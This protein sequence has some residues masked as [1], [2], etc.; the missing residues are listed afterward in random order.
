MTKTALT[1]LQDETKPKAGDRLK[2]GEILKTNGTLTSPNG[3]FIFRNQED[4]NFVLY[5]KNFENR[6]VWASKTD[7]AE[8]DEREIRWIIIQPDGN[9]VMTNSGDKSVKW[10]SKTGGRGNQTSVFILQ[11][12]GNA[13][14]ISDEKQIWQTDTRQRSSAEEKMPL[15]AGERLKP[16]DTMTSADGRFRLIMQGDC[17]L[18]LYDTEDNNRALWSSNSATNYYTKF[19]FLVSNDGNLLV[20]DEKNGRIWATD[21]AGKGDQTAVLQI[22]SNGTLLFSCKNVTI[23][24]TEKKPKPKTNRL[25]P[26]E[27][28]MSGDML[29]S[30]NGR[31][32]LVMQADGSLVIIDLRDNNRVI[33]PPESKPR[34]GQ[35]SAT[36]MK[37]G[38]FVILR[39][40]KHAWSTKTPYNEDAFLMLQDD[41]SAVV[42]SKDNKEIWNSDSAI[43]SLRVNRL[44][45]G[46]RLERG[47][48]L[49]SLDG[50]FKLKMQ[51]DG[52]CV[53]YEN[54]KAIWDTSTGSDAQALFLRDDDNLVLV[55]SGWSSNTRRRRSGG[56]AALILQN[57]GKLV[58]NSEGVIIWSNDSTL[59]QKWAP[60]VS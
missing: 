26:G 31:F 20:W 48:N 4:G 37:G 5:D 17:N 29:T 22:R 56:T 13:V 44:T 52:N 42:I 9:A 12:D 30:D 19:S 53:L 43:P 55:G 24:Q 54:V 1:L 47:Q 36:M 18:V 2:I 34:T 15:K 14:I 23:F 27:N 11:D 58:L 10:S 60:R 33:W 35:V 25:N 41:G 28:L 8:E 21:T 50:K 51:A 39:D 6:V 59:I 40:K 16:Y 32:T 7:I 45:A 38:K 46:A 57:D 49:T 3:R